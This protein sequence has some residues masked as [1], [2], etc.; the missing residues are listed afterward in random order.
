VCVC[1]CMCVCDNPIIGKNEGK[2]RK[3]N[4]K[5]S[6]FT[7]SSRTG[8]NYSYGIETKIYISFIELLCA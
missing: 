3:C 2:T 7:D 4:R 1:V 8:D 6:L 5:I